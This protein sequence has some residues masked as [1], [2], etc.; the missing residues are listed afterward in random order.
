MSD[1]QSGT[2]IVM[3]V[4][5]GLLAAAVVYLQMEISALQHQNQIVWGDSTSQLRYAAG[6]VVGIEAAQTVTIKTEKF[7]RAFRT[8]AATRVYNAENTV[9][10]PDRLKAG[11]ALR[12]AF[13]KDSDG[14]WYLKIARIK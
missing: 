2:K 6:T 1:K 11:D 3:L 10:G 8:S 14:D 13:M 9:G 4:I 7:T 12:F 5:G